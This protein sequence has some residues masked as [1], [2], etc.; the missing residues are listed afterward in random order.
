MQV[1][2]N[3]TQNTGFC[4]GRAKWG[5]SCSLP[6]AS[7]LRGTA[8]PGSTR[9]PQHHTFMGIFSK[10]RLRSI[11]RREDMPEGLWVKCPECGALIHVLE[12]KQ[13]HQVC[14]P[15]GHHFLMESRE[16]IA[17]SSAGVITREDLH[18]DL[19]VADRIEALDDARVW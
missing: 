15:C 18:R 12:L 7:F 13:N 2:K 19:L 1:G 14:L 9:D 16:R 10:P 17:S 8:F 4:D 3:A 11:D 6:A 5:L